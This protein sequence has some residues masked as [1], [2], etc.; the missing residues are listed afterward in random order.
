MVAGF[1]NVC[2]KGRPTAKN[3]FRIKRFSNYKEIDPIFFLTTF[4][5]Q[6]GTPRVDR[7]TS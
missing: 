5:H 4:L 2:T 1:M 7:C 3:E 6:D